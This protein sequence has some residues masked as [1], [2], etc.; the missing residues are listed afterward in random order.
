MQNTAQGYI[1]ATKKQYPHIEMAA[2]LGK[3]MR[4]LQA[5]LVEFIEDFRTIDPDDC[6]IPILSPRMEINLEEL[7]A[8]KE[9]KTG[10]NFSAKMSLVLYLKELT[11]EEAFEKQVNHDYLEFH[12]S[13]PRDSRD[14]DGNVK[15]L[16]DINVKYGMM[17]VNEQTRRVVDNRKS[18]KT[19]VE[20]NEDFGSIIGNIFDKLT[21]DI[22]TFIVNHLGENTNNKFKSDPKLPASQTRQLIEGVQTETNGTTTEKT[23]SPLG[24]TT[25]KRDLGTAAMFQLVSDRAIETPANSDKWPVIALHEIDKVKNQINTLSNYL[26]AVCDKEFLFS[27]Y[28]LSEIEKNPSGAMP[29]IGKI[30]DRDEPTPKVISKSRILEN[31]H[32]TEEHFA[33]NLSLRL[34]NPSAIET[35]NGWGDIN[36]LQLIGQKIDPAEAMG[37]N[38]LQI[39]FQGDAYHININGG[40]K[41]NQEILSDSIGGAPAFHELL[42]KTINATLR[43]ISKFV[44]R[45]IPG[46]TVATL[47]DIFRVEEKAK[48]LR[49]LMHTQEFSQQPQTANNNGGAPSS[50]KQYGM[51]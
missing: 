36:I 6:L 21:V 29:I 13:A 49:N 14:A 1:E 17:S 32:N 10:D 15:E 26:M 12:C 11:G 31:K 24:T 27:K 33:I 22:F 20:G 50:D 51:N 44:N 18:H 45:N 39:P 16:R 47:Y 3:E 46:I 34:R 2:T 35:D 30:N 37:N 8:N 23:D 9:G 40:Y 28:L 4:K 5:R 43:H 48:Q 19:S 38:E 41:G 7:K 25:S 42:E